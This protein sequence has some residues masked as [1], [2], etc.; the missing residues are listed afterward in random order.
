MV[1]FKYRQL[2]GVYHQVLSKKAPLYLSVFV[3]VEGI[4]GV[5][6]KGIL[7]VFLLPVKAFHE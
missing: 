7:G 1:I 4:S 6:G 3:T 5:V 2:Y